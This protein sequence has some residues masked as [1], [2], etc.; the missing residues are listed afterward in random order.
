MKGYVQLPVYIES[1]D[2]TVLAFT[3]EAYV[4]P[5]MMVLILLGEDFQRTY[6]IRVRQ[7]VDFGTD[8]LVGGEK[9]A[10]EVR[11]V[12]KMPDF[13][14]KARACG[15][16]AQCDEDVKIP[17]GIGK[18]VTFSRIPDAF[19][20]SEW[21][22]ERLLVI[23]KK[24]AY[25]TVPS[26]LIS[27]HTLRISVANPSNRPRILRKGKTLGTLLPVTML[28]KLRSVDHWI[29]MKN[30][31]DHYSALVGAMQK[32]GGPRGSLFHEEAVGVE[33]SLM[34]S[35]E[36][37]TARARVFVVE[38][39]GTVHQTTLQD[40]NL[41]TELPPPSN[42]GRPKTAEVPNSTVYPSADIENILDVGQLPEH[43]KIKA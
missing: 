16:L 31:A 22:I 6:E 34:T 35:L 27:S 29:A 42:P 37:R 5:N 23:D 26:A 38:T 43:L 17:A 33:K 8:I 19:P 9:Y 2:G 21:M 30:N 20:T 4:V 32:V 28:D 14:R 25:L 15:L 11:G 24:E 3:A 12:R 40:S 7:R 41:A 10:I 13:N 39:D 1:K 18:M 36:P